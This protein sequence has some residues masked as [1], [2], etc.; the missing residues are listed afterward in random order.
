MYLLDTDICIYIIKGRPAGVLRTLKKKTK[1]DI[2]ISSVSVAELQYGVEK[3]RFVDRN[4]VALLEFL[5]IFNIIDFDDRDALEYGRIRARLEKTGAIIGPMDLLISAQ[6]KE[7]NL[8]LV[9]N[10][11]G[12]F[13]RIDGLRIENW[14]KK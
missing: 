9:T 12:E 7:R 6:A 4:R 14:A 8:V 13:E 2:Y 5:S 10:N 1:D 3:S 11:T